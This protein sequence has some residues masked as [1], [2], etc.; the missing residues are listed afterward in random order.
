MLGYYVNISIPIPYLLV[1][2]P[3]ILYVFP[4]VVGYY[5]SKGLISTQ[6]NSDVGK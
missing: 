5:F 6:N 1:E 2:S 3:I 4:V